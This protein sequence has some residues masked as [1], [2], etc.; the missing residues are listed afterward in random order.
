MSAVLRHL[1]ITILTGVFLLVAEPARAQA[2]W[3]GFRNDTGT[4]LIIQESVSVGTGSK[5]AKPQKIFANETVRETPPSGGEHRVFTI[6]DP[7]HPDKPL[8]TGRFQAPPANENV[9]YVIKLTKGELVIEPIKTA[10]TSSTKAHP[11]R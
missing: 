6:Y 10:S 4:T 2:G 7:A 11:K 9:L 3:M 5:Q 1:R 8:Y